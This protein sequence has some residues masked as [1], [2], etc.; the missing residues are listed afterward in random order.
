MMPIWIGC[1]NNDEEIDCE[2]IDFAFPSLFIRLV[3]DAGTNLIENGTIDPDD[4]SVQGDFKS[5]GF[6]IIPAREFA[7]PDAD[8][9]E[10]DHTIMLFIP[11]QST[12][13][14][15]IHWSDMNSIQV[16]FSA[17][18]TKL[19]CFLFYYKPIGGVFKNE[20]FD[21]REIPPLQFV[22]ELEL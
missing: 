12:F 21:F 8:I 1:S 3:D 19:P 10:L 11:N 2:L 14:Y 6:Q 16:D 20:T 17:E 18:F 4:I 9:R 15:T 7:L 13:Q 22:A 5:P